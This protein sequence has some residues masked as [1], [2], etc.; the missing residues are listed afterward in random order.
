MLQTV[1]VSQRS[2]I[3]PETFFQ[4]ASTIVIWVK[5]WVNFSDVMGITSRS[6]Q[7][8]DVGMRID[9]LKQRRLKN[10]KMKFPLFQHSTNHRMEP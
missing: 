8:L 6:F 7:Q 1:P 4:H 9:K 5:S 10:A 2:E 3:L